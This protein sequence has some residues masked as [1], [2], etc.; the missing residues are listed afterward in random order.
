MQKEIKEKEETKK[1]QIQAEKSTPAR[2]AKPS[3]KISIAAVKKNAQMQDQ[4]NPSNY[5]QGQN[6]L[7]GLTPVSK[8][9]EVDIKVGLKKG[10][11]AM[12]MEES[13]FNDK[14]DRDKSLRLVEE[15]FEK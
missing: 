7:V 15:D 2:S 13:K 4:Y 6:R 1:Q 10:A 8:D 3:E 14:D 9:E 12:A 11:V 5:E